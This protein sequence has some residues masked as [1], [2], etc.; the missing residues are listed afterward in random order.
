MA[1]PENDRGRT[2]FATANVLAVTALDVMTARQLSQQPRTV[3]RA[4][5]DE[6]L[7]RTHRSVTVRRPVEEVYA[8]WHDFTNLPRFMRHLES[9]QMLDERRSHW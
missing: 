3:T 1:N 7:V 4:R 9:V 6:G 2:A 5:M 8:F